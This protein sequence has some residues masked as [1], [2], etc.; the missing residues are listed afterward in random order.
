MPSQRS[1]CRSSC[2]NS[3]VLFPSAGDHHAPRRC[4][5]LTSPRVLGQPMPPT[6]CHRVVGTP[7][8]TSRRSFYISRLT[9]EILLLNALLLPPQ[10]KHLKTFKVCLEFSHPPELLLPLHN[11]LLNHSASVHGLGATCRTSQRSFPR[12]LAF[13]SS[14]CHWEIIE[15]WLMPNSSDVTCVRDSPLLG[16]ILQSL[17][18]GV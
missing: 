6:T 16:E 5:S 2:L 12:V 17:P 18:P 7:C 11:S 8:D 9:P 1:S 10:G 14:H 4:C 13:L 15:L 3:S